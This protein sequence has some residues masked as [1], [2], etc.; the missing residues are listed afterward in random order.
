MT[1]TL[2]FKVDWYETSI[3]NYMISKFMLSF[4]FINPPPS[5]AEKKSKKFTRLIRSYILKAIII[6]LGYSSR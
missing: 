5:F 1:A 3:K 2:T 4:I 6:L